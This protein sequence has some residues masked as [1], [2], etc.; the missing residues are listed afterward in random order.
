[1][2][3]LLVAARD[4][5][6]FGQTALDLLAAALVLCERARR[7]SARLPSYFHLRSQMKVTKAKGLNTSPLEWFASATRLLPRLWHENIQR[8]TASVSSLTLSRSSS[9]R[10]DPV[11][12]RR[13]GMQQWS[14]FGLALAAANKWL[15]AAAGSSRAAGT[16]AKAQPVAAASSPQCAYPWGVLGSPPLADASRPNGLLF[17]PFALVTFIWA[18]K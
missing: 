2:T 13:G 1:M 8:A 15:Q 4:G 10:L 17:R 18:S 5:V 14:Q 12:P 3:G 16:A 6:S 7:V 9:L 11:G